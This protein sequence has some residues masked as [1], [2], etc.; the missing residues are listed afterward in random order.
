MSDSINVSVDNSMNVVLASDLTVPGDLTMISGL[1]SL[2]AF[3]LEVGGTAAGKRI[4]C[5]NQWQR[6]VAP[7]T[8]CQSA[9][10]LQPGNPCTDYV[11]S[12]RVTDQVLS[13]GDSGSPVVDFVV[14]RTWFIEEDVP[15]GSDLDITLQWNSGDQFGTFTPDESYIAHYTSGAW[16]GSGVSDGTG[17]NL[18]FSGVTT[19]SPFFFPIELLAFT[20]APKGKTVQLDWRTATELNNAF[21]HIERSANGRDFSEIGKVAGAGTSHT[22]LDYAFTDQLPQ[23]GWNYYRLRQ[24]DFDGQF[25][26]SPV[27][28]VQM[29]KD[30]TVRLQLFPNPA[31]NA[32]NLKTDRLIEPADRL[33]IYDY[34]GRQ[35]MSCSASDAVSAPMDISQLPA[36]TYVVRLRMA[37]GTTNAAFVKQ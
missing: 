3:D 14:N 10:F 7:I 21:F 17:F 24:V 32:L 26:Y 2:G 8:I 11:F 31:N 35:V 28:A 1:L 34:T 37:E 13:N 20:A 25:S 5:A 29:G 23:T 33:E 22:P 12:A 18:T 9:Q 15:D 30:G 6:Q 27:Q 4:V 36:G 19:P 16:V